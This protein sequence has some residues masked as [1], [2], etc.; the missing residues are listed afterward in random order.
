METSLLLLALVSKTVEER[1]KALSKKI[2]RLKF[3]SNGFS[4]GGLPSDQFHYNKA[5]DD[6]LLLIG[7]EEEEKEN[8]KTEND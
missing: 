8:G 5:I 4:L 7:Y 6:V 3:N 1:N 2:E